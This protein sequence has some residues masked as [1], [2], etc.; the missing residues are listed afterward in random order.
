MIVMVCKLDNP[1]SPYDW[2]YREISVTIADDLSR[3]AG[4]TAKNICMEIISTNGS[5]PE[6]LIK[7][8]QNIIATTNTTPVYRMLKRLVLYTNIVNKGE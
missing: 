2:F 1:A 4:F 8:V 3:I 7:A 5:E 6:K